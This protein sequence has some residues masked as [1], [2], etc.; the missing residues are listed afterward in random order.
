MLTL[1]V[2]IIFVFLIFG[3]L[4]RNRGDSFVDTIGKG[5]WTVL[6]ILILMTLVIGALAFA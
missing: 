6:I 4:F 2:I 3:L 1:L 5:C